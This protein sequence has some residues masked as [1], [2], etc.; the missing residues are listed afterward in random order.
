MRR[1]TFIACTMTIILMLGCFKTTQ[2][3]EFNATVSVLTPTIQLTNKDIFKN[4]EIQVKE[5][6]NNK[7]WTTD[8]FSAAERI[9][10][11]IQ[12]TIN[13]YSGN[14]Y[15]ANI[16]V[17]SSRPVYGTNYNTTLF[18]FLDKNFIF[19]YKQFQAL[20]YQENTYISELT[21]VLA[22]YSYIMLGFDYDSF[23]KYG[24]QN[25]FQKAQ[26]IVNSATSSTGP[27]WSGMEKDDHN[28]YYLINNILDERFKP[29]REA[30]YN[31]HRLGLDYM[32]EDNE[33][34]LNK[35]IES[36]ATMAEMR[37][38]SVS[39]FVLSLY[40]S[41]KSIELIDLFSSASSDKREKARDILVV[42]DPLNA[43]KYNEKLK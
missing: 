15:T 38:S 4:L 35:I 12:I 41:A 32:A 40:F 13:S 29:F 11:S 36:L 19:N 14:D 21:S 43:E 26:N 16:Q 20:D 10:C 23:S 3:Q 22:Y 24:G 42:A 17:V 39:N 28:R 33:K 27:G 2:A 30:F 6:M 9:E 25:F 31:Y 1:I 18:N 34:G 5:F 8:N 37:N 7:H